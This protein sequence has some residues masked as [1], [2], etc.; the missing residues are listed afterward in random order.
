MAQARALGKKN[1]A[2]YKIFIVQKS[3][4]VGIKCDTTVLCIFGLYMSMSDDAVEYL[5]RIGWAHIVINAIN[6]YME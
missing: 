5:F 6:W 4:H 3:A 1:N 2:V